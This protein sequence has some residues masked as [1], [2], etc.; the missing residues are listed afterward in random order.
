MSYQEKNTTISLFA[1]LFIAGYYLLKLF[2]MIQ[3]GGLVAGRLFNLWAVVVVTVILVVVFGNILANIILAIVH[4][5][6]TGQQESERF[7]EDERDKL[8]ELKGSKVSYLTFSLGV[9]LA[10]LTFASGQSPLVMFS[11]IIFFS[12]AAEIAGDVAQIIL[13]HKGV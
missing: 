1:H 8:I 13:Y 7:I 11:L 10:M 5:I 4:A 9:L 2:Q 12:I 3:D 6:R